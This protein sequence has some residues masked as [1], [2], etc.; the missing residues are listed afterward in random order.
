MIL[1]VVVVYRLMGFDVA[2]VVADVATKLLHLIHHL[3]YLGVFIGNHTIQLEI[4]CS[5]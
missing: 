5:K 4:I 1:I 2:V 3:V